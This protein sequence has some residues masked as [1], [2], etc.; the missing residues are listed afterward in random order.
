MPHINTERT[1]KKKGEWNGFPH[2]IIVFLSVGSLWAGSGSMLSNLS[3]SRGSG[4]LRLTAFCPVRALEKLG[5]SLTRQ[6]KWC[7]HVHHH[8]IPLIPHYSSSCHCLV[9]QGWEEGMLGMKKSG[10]RLIIIPPTLA[11]GSKGVPNRVPAHS[12]L[13]F[14][15]ELRRVTSTQPFSASFLCLLLCSTFYKHNWSFCHINNSTGSWKVFAWA[16]FIKAKE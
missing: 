10:R 1:S 11:Y 9:G 6:Q 8:H 13:I 16:R 15:A 5:T 7:S 3:G 4:D 12:T 14:E 2:Q